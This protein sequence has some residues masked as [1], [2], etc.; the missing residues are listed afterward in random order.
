MKH[1]V[2]SREGKVKSM[3]RRT[4]RRVSLPARVCVCVCGGGELPFVHAH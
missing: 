1:L 2:Y 3:Q 4:V